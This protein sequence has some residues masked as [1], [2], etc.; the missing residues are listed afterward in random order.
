VQEEKEKAERA[1]YLA[2]NAQLKMLRYQL[3]PHFLFNSLNSIWALIDEDTRASKAMIS[4]LSEFLRY[5]L[6]SK[7]SIEVPLHQELEAIQHYLSIEKKRFEE[8][9][10]INYDIDPNTENI[11]ILSFF[12]HPIV[13]NAVKYGMKTSVLPLKILLSSKLE[14]DQLVLTVSNTGKWIE[15][16]ENISHENTGTGIENIRLRLQQKFPGRSSFST[17]ETDGVIKV[18]ITI[19]ISE[20]DGTLL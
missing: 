14:N 10:E 8:K 4:E 5:T 17:E 11:H 15:P 7:D 16:S 18:R 19:N 1:A 9:I 2:Q 3:N 12:L 13:E 6:I 20:K